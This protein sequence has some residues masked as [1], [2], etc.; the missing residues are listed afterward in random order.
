[1]NESGAFVVIVAEL[2]QL[3]VKKTV[4][5]IVNR[6]LFALNTICLYRTISVFIALF[7]C[8]YWLIEN[9]FNENQIKQISSEIVTFYPKDNDLF[10]KVKFQN[11]YFERI[12]FTLRYEPIA[13]FMLTIF[14]WFL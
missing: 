3:L 11:Y 1:M 7:L 5:G 4:F 12:A 10:I 9:Y 14:Y 8:F 6:V 13:W 2:Q